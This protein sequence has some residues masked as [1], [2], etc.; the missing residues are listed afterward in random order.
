M[1]TMY[2][3]QQLLKRF[4][5]IIYTGNKIADLEL[6]Q[7]EVRELYEQKLIDVNEFKDAI[8]IIRAAHNKLQ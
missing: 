7:E 1:K 8:I 3:V 6:I 4:G 5:T 2:D